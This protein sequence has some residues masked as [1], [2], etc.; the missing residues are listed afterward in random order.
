MRFF[1]CAAFCIAG[2]HASTVYD[3]S[4]SLTGTRGVDTFGGLVDGGGNGYDNLTLSWSIVPLANLTYEYIYTISGFTGPSLSKVILNLSANCMTGNPSPG[5]VLS[6][7]VDGLP[8]TA[9]L[10]DWCYGHPGCQGS[11]NV[12]LPNDIAGVKFSSL[13]S[14]AVTITFN[15]PR[16]P[17]WGDIYLGGGQQYLYN[18]GN[19]NHLDPNILDFIARP[20][21]FGFEPPTPEPA[22]LG[23]TGVALAL[24]GVM[25]RRRSR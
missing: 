23:L 12:G 16:A 11:S 15:S 8:A 7:Q 18:L 21:A 6:A 3:T 2:L 1:V 17:V 10:G 19:P 4:A 24:L 22:T 5:C 13:P 25:G 20:G 14:G 9:A